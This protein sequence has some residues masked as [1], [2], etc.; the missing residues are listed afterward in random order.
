MVRQKLMHLIYVHTIKDKIKNVFHCR[1][2]SI[3]T[4]NIHIVFTSHAKT[5]TKGNAALNKNNAGEKGLNVSGQRAFAFSTIIL[6]LACYIR[7]YSS[8]TNR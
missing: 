1:A 8:T 4:V 7:V 2:H 3:K 6:M 5:V